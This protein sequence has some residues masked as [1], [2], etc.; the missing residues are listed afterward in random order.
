MSF[1]TVQFQLY[2][3]NRNG[4]CG[5]CISCILP[6]ERAVRLKTE[7]SQSLQ[8]ES[9]EWRDSESATQPSTVSVHTAFITNPSEFSHVM[10]VVPDIVFQML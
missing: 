8:S 9:S 5:L 3:I 1:L 10:C 2:C 4:D 7:L 6:V